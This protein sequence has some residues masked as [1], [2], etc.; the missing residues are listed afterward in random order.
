[1]AT[2]PEFPDPEKY[3]KYFAATIEH[4][5]GAPGPDYKNYLTYFEFMN[6]PPLGPIEKPPMTHAEVFKKYTDFFNYAAL[7]LSERYPG[8]KFG[9]GGFME[10]HYIDDLMDACG[11]NLSWI[12]RHPYGH[13]G[14]A[15]FALQ[16]QYAKHAHE[17]GLDDLKFIVSEWDF[18][19]YGEPAFDYI[20]QRW[21]PVADH[22][23][24]CIGTLH[25]RWSE[26]TEGGY[27]FGVDGQ[28][29]PA[30][31]YGQLP[32]EWPNPGIDKPITYRYD[33]FWA[34]RNLRGQQYAATLD[35]PELKSSLS[36]R[37]YAL[38]TSDGKQFNILVYCGYPYPSLSNHHSVE[39]IKLHVKATIPPEIKGRS[40][41]IAKADAHTVSES[42]PQTLDGDT[43]DMD[44]EVPALSA[45]S[46]IVR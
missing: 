1:M 39:K 11:K 36:Q 7:H 13:T 45:V 14:E 5:N 43:I 9:A 26:Y 22:A 20:M 44:I 38:A 21:K 19:I 42:E 40:L 41:I 8:M 10:S 35:V 33:A 17:Q 23:D 3:T 25:Y 15:V 46:L 6:E 32:P 34:V 2:L 28:A 37:A 12:S 24:S 30:H 31:P 27:V 16:D 18:W 4:F 29:D